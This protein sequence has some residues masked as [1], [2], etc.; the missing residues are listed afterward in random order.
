MLYY[1]FIHF[2][3][4]LCCYSPDSYSKSSNSLTLASTPCIFFWF[5]RILQRLFSTWRKYGVKLGHMPKRNKAVH[6]LSDMLPCTVF[7]PDRQNK[8][9]SC[10]NFMFD[11]VQFSTSHYDDAVLVVWLGFWKT[12][13]LQLKS[14]WEIYSASC[15]YPPSCRSNNPESTN[16]VCFDSLQETDWFFS[17]HQNSWLL[18]YSALLEI[19]F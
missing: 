15:S 16:S 9:S 19:V 7:Q 6:F 1:F 10:C 4:E 3:A 14:K 18:L 17:L 8:S 2:H 11:W 5:S 13:P 12:P